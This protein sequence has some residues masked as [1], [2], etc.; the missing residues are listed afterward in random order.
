MAALDPDR[1][2][3]PQSAAALAEV[4]FSAADIAAAPGRESRKIPPRSIIVACGI[5]LLVVVAGA[6][7]GIALNQM[8]AHSQD[9]KDSMSAGL[10]GSPW[11]SP[12]A[13]PSRAPSPSPSTKSSV[14]TTPAKKR[15]VSSSAT[16]PAGIVLSGQ[17][18]LYNTAT[19]LCLGERLAPT[20]NGGVNYAYTEE[21][22]DKARTLT[23]SGE[24]GRY[25]LTDNVQNGC[26]APDPRYLGQDKDGIL[27]MDCN[28]S[29]AATVEWNFVGT[30]TVQLI[31]R[32]D[33]ARCLTAK[34]VST[35]GAVPGAAYLRMYGCGADGPAAL[36]QWTLRKAQ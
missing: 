3:R 31:L 11:A 22:C 32:A 15:T 7:G 10:P 35:P 28:P 6:G 1:D 18:Q 17:Y 2:S 29:S 12:G 27:P 26:V 5:A 14:T 19:E 13:S 25:R 8:H 34:A 21:V 30:T 16:A 20:S 23:I 4:F 9:D 33:P 36:Q 24:P